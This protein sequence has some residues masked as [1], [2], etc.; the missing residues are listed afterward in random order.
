[1]LAPVPKYDMAPYS[2]PNCAELEASPVSSLTGLVPS[3]T[4]VSR[5]YPSSLIPPLLACPRP[6]A[7]REAGGRKSQVVFIAAPRARRALC[8]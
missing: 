3:V 8:R 7:R 1:M 2:R 4:L 5:Y 6:G